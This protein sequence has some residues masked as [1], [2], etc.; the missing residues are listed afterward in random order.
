MYWAVRT[1]VFKVINIK[2]FLKFLARSLLLLIM[3]ACLSLVCPTV[4]MHHRCLY[5][6]MLTD[7]GMHVHYEDHLFYVGY[8]MFNLRMGGLTSNETE[9]QFGRL[10]CLIVKWCHSMTK[11]TK[12]RILL[13]AE[14]D[15]RLILHKSWMWWKVLEM[16]I[17]FMPFT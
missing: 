5:T 15:S 2:S 13:A 10:L 3:S 12:L 17:T 14:N 9:I 6:K 7:M 4:R 8:E 11:S 1:T 16:S